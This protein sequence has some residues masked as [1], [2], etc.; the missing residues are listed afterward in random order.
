MGSLRWVLILAVAMLAPGQQ[1]SAT[2]VFTH[3][4]D[5]GPPWPVEDI[6][7]MDADGANVRAL[8]RDGHNHNPAWSPDGQHV[9]YV[10]DAA[11][12]K[13][14][15]NERS[16][17]ASHHPILTVPAAGFYG[18]ANSQSSVQRG[19]RLRASSRPAPPRRA[20]RMH[21]MMNRCEAVFSF[22]LRTVTM[23]LDCYSEMH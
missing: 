6:Y 16:E 2:V 20:Q 3:A 22:Y 4:P 21:P 10:H 18:K 8:T 17:F 11:L 5:G 14:M 13:P 9:L 23:H 15:P 19:R 12:Q 1:E 7:A